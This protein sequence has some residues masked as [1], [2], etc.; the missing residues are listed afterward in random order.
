MR[1]KASPYWVLA[2]VLTVCYTLATLVVPR[3]V[4]WNG[5]SQS[6]NVFKLL[7]GQGRRLFANEMFVMADV[8]F[9]SGYYPS[10]FDG[11]QADDDAAAP[12][13]GQTEDKD[14]TSDDFFGPPPDWID[15]LD[16]QFVPNRHTHLS[17]GGPSGHMKK[18]A[19]QEILP[20]LKLSADMNPEMIK[21]YTVGAYWL[22][23]S[24]HDPKEAQA[25]LFDGL[26]NNPGN[27]E[28]LF[29]L[30]RLYDESYHDT[31]RARHVWIAALRCWEAQKENVKTNSEV[32]FTKEEITMSLAKLEENAGNWPEAI[33]YLETVKKLS[34]DPSAIQKQ[35]DEVRKKM[36]AQGNSSKPQKN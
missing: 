20:W 12:A 30:G 2:L 16:R 14:S 7:L 6:D 9:H 17:A 22:R 19:V 11:R 4:H 31:N 32:K 33:Q 23:T 25:F 21:N 34:P 24:L 1:L 28:L 18:T 10:M 15:A 36:V 29:D 3:A 13:Y 8:Y 27:P 26:H 5:G 35:I